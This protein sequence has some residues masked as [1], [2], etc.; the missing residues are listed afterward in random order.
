MCL[1]IYFEKVFQR[2]QLSV[3]LIPVFVIIYLF[4]VADA[5]KRCCRMNLNDT[6]FPVDPQ[7]I[8]PDGT[9][10]IQ[11][12]C[13]K[14]RYRQKIRTTNYCSIVVGTNFA[15]KQWSLSRY[16]SLADQSHRV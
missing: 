7:D 15:N 12:F 4:S 9:P 10:C 1:Y 6:C 5:C 2:I 16:S 13:N 14:V 11:G 3:L 8:L